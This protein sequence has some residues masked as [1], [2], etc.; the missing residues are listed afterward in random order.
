MP[1]PV[2]R[3]CPSVRFTRILAGLM[4]LWTRPR[5]WSLP[6]AAAMPIG[7]A[8]E[9]SHLHRCAEQPVERLAARILEHQHGPTARRARAPAAAPPTP[10]PA[11]PSIR[12]RGRGDR[13]LTATG[14]QRRAERPAQRSDRRHRPRATLGRRRVRRPQ[15][16]PESRYLANTASFV[17]LG[18]RVHGVELCVRHKA[19]AILDSRRKHS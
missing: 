1:K 12:I 5:R 14:V 16:R 15:T 11:H 4:S 13:G 18:R 9:A 10:R 3:T 19:A 8:Q 6:S 2:S 7:K 17:R